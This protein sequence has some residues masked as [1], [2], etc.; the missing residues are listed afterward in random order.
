MKIVVKNISDTKVELTITLDAGAL[1]AAEQVAIKKLSRDVKVSGFRKGKTPISV[2]SKNIDPN[3]LQE[4]TIN[5]AIS[6]AVAEAFI[7]KDLRALDRPAVA[8]KKFVPGETIEFT[9]E[10]D[11]LPNVKLGNYKKLKA[12]TEKFEI[13]EKEVD[14]IIDRICKGFAE[15]TDVK[16]AAKMGDETVIDFVGKK[17]GVVFDGG[18][19][20]DYALTLGSGQFI[21]G[22]EEGIVG[23]KIGETFD[24]ELKFPADYGAEAL[25]GA[26]VT[27]TTT[28]KSIKEVVSPKLD[29]KLAAKAGPFKTVAELKADIKRELTSQK[30]RETNEKLKD[31]LVSQL[32]AISNVP[33]PEILIAD[34]MKSI[35]QDFTNNLMYQ[36]LSIDQYIENKKFKSKEDWIENEVKPVAIKRVQAGLVL[37]E[38]SKAEKIE[39]TTAELDKH[40]ETYRQQYSKNPEALKQF[41]QPEVRRDIANRLLTEKTVDRLVEL[42]KK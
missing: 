9:A 12:K 26:K 41:D 2:A 31:D 1:V 42:N 18:T 38:L 37:A 33:V 15:K 35:E 11:I 19:G 3:V 4:E 16:R 22:F 8:V 32:I 24:L 5:N 28:L 29:D 25:K 13:K 39:A 14:E 7:E 17:E 21:P 30:E 6:K 10:V 40:V 20:N 36:G 27:F 34:Q 23:H